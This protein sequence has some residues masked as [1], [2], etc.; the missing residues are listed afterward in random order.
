FFYT[1][2]LPIE[3]GYCNHHPRNAIDWINFFQV[4]DVWTLFNILLGLNLYHKHTSRLHKTLIVATYIGFLIISL[5]P[6]IAHTVSDICPPDYPNC[7]EHERDAIA[8]F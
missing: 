5:V 7:P 4:I 2:N 3:T 6:V 8:L 1:I